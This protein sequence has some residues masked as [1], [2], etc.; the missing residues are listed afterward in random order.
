MVDI[1]QYKKIFAGHNKK[2]GLKI[3]GELSKLN[4]APD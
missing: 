4:D 1:K 3:K 2:A